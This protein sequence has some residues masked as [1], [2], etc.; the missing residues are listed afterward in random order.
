MSPLFISAILQAVQDGL[1][2]QTNLPDL[3]GL[4]DL[5]EG[6]ATKEDADDKI[7]YG[8]VGRPAN[9]RRR[10]NSRRKSGPDNLPKSMKDYIPTDIDPTCQTLGTLVNQPPE[11]S[12]NQEVRG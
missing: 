10:R 2:A 7:G 8:C 11:G 4:D 3:S 5:N 6:G 12:G 1:E 9:D